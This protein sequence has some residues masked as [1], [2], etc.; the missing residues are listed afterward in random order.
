MVGR[1]ILE[2]DL[3]SSYEILSPPRDQLDLLDRSLTDKY[4]QTHQPDMV[5]HAAGL[6]GGIHANMLRNAE[7]LVNN[8]NIGQNIILSAHSN[9]VK[10]FL[11]LGSS[12][13]Y[14]KN[15]DK[16][17]NETK[18]LSGK[19]EETNEGYAIAKIAI[20]R[21]CEFITLSDKN[22]FY[23]TIIPCNLFGKYDN[24]DIETSHMIP[25]VI[26]KLHEAKIS[27]KTNVKIWGNGKARREFMDAKDLANFIFYS[28]DKFEQMPQYI[29]VGIGHDYSIDEYYH[30]IASVV[31]YEGTFLHDLS[32]PEGMK[33]KLVDISLQ[34][35]FGWKSK[36][37]L[38]ESLESA[39]AFYL[40]CQL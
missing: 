27:K 13:M 31:Q 3:S 40:D 17:L 11:N 2:N 23:K 22:R 19:L 15:S 39:Y 4:I 32:K 28:I 36:S 12:C 21:L 14:P 1:N 38:I 24:F 37:T 10:Y 18:I 30:L 33:R 7:F 20:A 25:A 26:R 34:L 16:P 6:V 5:I 9:G 8:F 29:N 35:D